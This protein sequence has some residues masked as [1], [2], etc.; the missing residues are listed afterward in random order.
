MPIDPGR[1]EHTDLVHKPHRQS[2]RAKC[3]DQDPD[4]ERG[5]AC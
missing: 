3:A 1:D 2:E 5:L 4:K